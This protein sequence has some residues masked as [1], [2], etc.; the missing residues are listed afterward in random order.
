MTDILTRIV[1]H[2][3]EEVAERAQRL[4]LPVLRERCSAQPGPRS[5]LDALESRIRQRR[6]AVI[7]EIKKASPSRGVI[8]EDFDPEAIADS[9]ARGGAACLSV[10]TDEQF[11]Q[12]R[13]EYLTRARQRCELPALRKDF[14]IDP[15]QVWES[16]AIGADCILL[17]V[18]A[19]GDAQLVDLSGLALELGMDVLVEVHDREEL[20]RALE[21]KI[22]LLGIN[23]RDL[24]TFETS[25]DT[26]FELLDD[27]PEGHVVITESG[28]HTRE[29]V[30]AMQQRGVYGFL[31]GEAF[32]RAA[33]P[34]RELARLF[35]LSWEGS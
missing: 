23:N 3:A 27:I 17:I 19:L 24:R 31:I 33:E 7:A 13:D 1:R 11:F 5:F 28:I 6:P 26:T 2:K 4:P 30:T 32:M 8:R 20:E 18:A 25:L 34:G 22:P 16:R 35:E 21:L 14:M 10:L 9:Y 15:Y 12:G 29:D